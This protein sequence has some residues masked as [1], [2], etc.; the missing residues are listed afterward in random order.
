[1]FKLC[2]KVIIWKMLATLW[3]LF[4]FVAPFFF[5]CTKTGMSRSDSRNSVNQDLNSPRS[6]GGGGGLS[7]ASMGTGRHSAARAQTP[8]RRGSS[9]YIGG[10]DSGVFLLLI[11]FISCRKLIDWGFG[12]NVGNTVPAANPQSIFAFF[13]IHPLLL[14][15]TFICKF[16][17]RIVCVHIASAGLPPTSPASPGWAHRTPSVR[18]KPSNVS[19]VSMSEGSAIFETLTDTKPRL[20]N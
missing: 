3:F 6:G 7:L 14:R 2:Q 13:F 4:A 9:V 19:T 15:R 10:D 11:F 5:I 8:S 16:D 17:L 1:M 12:G 20:P 18:R